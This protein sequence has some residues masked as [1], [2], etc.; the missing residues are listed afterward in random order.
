MKL[1]YLSLGLL[2]LVSCKSDP[3]FEKITSVTAYDSYLNTKNTP[4]LYET[5]LQQNFWSKR[6]N[7]DTTGIGDI[8]PLAGVYEQLFTETGNINHLLVAE[9]L[10]QKGIAVAAD[11]FRDGFERGLAKNYI[12]QHRFKEAKE[13]LQKSFENKAQK[14]PTLHMLFDCAMELGEY[15]SAYQYLS[16]LKDMSDY[17]YLIRISKWSDHIGDLDNAI[18]FMEMAKGKAESHNSTPLKIWTYSNLADYYGHAG[19]IKD[20][21]DYYLKTLA[22]QPDNSYVKRKLAW[23]VYAA[24]GNTR[25]S[26]RI[27]DSVMKNHKVPDYLL[28]KSELYTFE[29][30]ISASKKA[31]EAFVNAV[32]EG[33][34]GDM[35]N[36]YLIELYA[37]ASPKKA[38]EIAEKEVINRNTPLINSYLAFAQLKNGHIEESLKT[39]ETHV[40]GKTFEPMALY[41]SALVYKA[42]SNTKKV[43][44]I[45]NELKEATFELGPVMA[46]Q[47]LDL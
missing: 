31:E 47:V 30:N 23:I 37:E 29:G 25:E 27:L 5:Q 46:N 21:Y 34:Y 32:E 24:E 18:K 13:I 12:S 16:E 44:E 11:N 19:R 17:N 41:F 35:Y 14:R 6:L 42:S 9:K 15:D 3:K 7:K 20:S 39:I 22:L 2:F 43:K 4:T 36:T 26:H 33:N 40:E 28:L 38:L 1:L 45:K 8:G 10:Y